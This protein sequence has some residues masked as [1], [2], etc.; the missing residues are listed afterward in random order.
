MAKQRDAQG[1][2]QPD[3]VRFPSGMANLSAYVHSRGLKMGIYEASGGGTCCGFPGTDGPTHAIADVDQFSQWEIDMLKWDGCGPGAGGDYNKSY[4]A[5]YHALTRPGVRP[6]VYSCSWPAYIN[7]P[8]TCW[9]PAGV[10]KPEGCDFANVAGGTG[11]EYLSKI[12]NMWRLYSDITDVYSSGAGNPKGF[13]GIAEYWALKQDELAPWNGP[14]HWNDPDM[15]EIGNQGEWG[16]KGNM[17]VA[18]RR[19]HMALW[20]I[21]AGAFDDDNR[22]VCPVGAGMTL[23]PT[24]HVWCAPV[25]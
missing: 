6:M 3:P 16:A 21:F 7:I 24:L 2:L 22:L 15:L 20:C 13:A 25:L 8:G 23:T 9:S 12:C 18:E 11:Y 17:T 5:M 14:G 19:S 1:R 10:P 4:T